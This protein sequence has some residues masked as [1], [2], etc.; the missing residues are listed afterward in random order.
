MWGQ[1]ISAAHAAAPREGSGTDGLEGQGADGLESQGAFPL[2]GPHDELDGHEVQVEAC[3]DDQA[4]A[5]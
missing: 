2:P 3:T 1:G 5:C 4:E